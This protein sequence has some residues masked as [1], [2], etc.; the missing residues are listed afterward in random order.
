VLL[1]LT[2][3]GT[4]IGLREFE[5]VEYEYNHVFNAPGGG[6]AAKTTTAPLE[7]IDTPP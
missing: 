4:G 7:L 6:D 1:L 2:P 3:A 5:A